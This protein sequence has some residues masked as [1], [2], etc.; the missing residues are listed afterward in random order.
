MGLSWKWGIPVYRYTKSSNVQ[1]NENQTEKKT[2]KW[3][4]PPENQTLNPHFQWDKVPFSNG[5]TIQLELVVP[6]LPAVSRPR[7]FT[8]GP[9]AGVRATFLPMELGP[10]TVLS[11]QVEGS[12]IDMFPS[13]NMKHI[14]QHH[15]LGGESCFFRLQKPCLIHNEDSRWEIGIKHHLR[16]A[17]LSSAKTRCVLMHWHHFLMSL[18]SKRCETGHVESFVTA[19][20]SSFL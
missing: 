12:G 11:S 17:C 15:L 10:A 13:N 7:A 8:S 6:G 4:K 14:K 1:F 5:I 18:V 16:N 3:D 20:A 2:W 19:R 9:V